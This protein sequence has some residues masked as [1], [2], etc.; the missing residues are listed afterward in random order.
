LHDTVW[1][2]IQGIPSVSIA[3]S[4][5]TDAA[6]TQAKALG[7][8]DAKRVFVQHPI[9]DANDEEMKTKANECINDVIAALT[10]NN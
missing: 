6:E 2:E 8:N 5:F 9:Q 3:S 7:L 10:D 1:F 4:E